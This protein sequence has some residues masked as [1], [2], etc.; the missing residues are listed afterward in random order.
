MKL[1]EIILGVVL[2]AI[3]GIVAWE[4]FGEETGK[5]GYVRTLELL[6]NFEG[7]Q[8][9]AQAFDSK[10]VAYSVTLDSMQVAFQ[11]SV[12]EYQTGSAEMTESE[13]LVAEQQLA[14]KQ[15]TLQ[16]Y[17]Q[18]AQNQLAEEEETM[19]RGVLNQMEAFMASY[20]QQHGYQL[21]LGT[22]EDGSI[23]YGDKAIDLTN[24]IGLALNEQYRGNLNNS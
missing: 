3:L 21:I 23:L 10:K 24:E 6:E 18:A 14:N 12:T 7:M 19:T 9:A 16:Q 17:A 5:I 11:A 22:S 1:K 2:C 13:R 4:H 8:E 15:Q 20:G